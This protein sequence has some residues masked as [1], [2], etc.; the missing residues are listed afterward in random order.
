MSK[1]NDSNKLAIQMLI[2]M[3]PVFL[4]DCCSWQDAS[5]SVQT[6]LFGLR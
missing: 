2:A 3:V 5:I 6:A 4:P 1:M